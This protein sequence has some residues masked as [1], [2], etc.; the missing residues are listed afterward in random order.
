M[1]GSVPNIRAASDYDVVM[2]AVKYIEQLQE[3]LEAAKSRQNEV[4]NYSKQQLLAKNQQHLAASS[5]QCLA[6]S[7]IDLSGSQMG[8]YN[9][10][11]A[12]SSIDISSSG[13]IGSCNKNLAASSI[14]LSSSSRRQLSYSTTDLN[15]SCSSTVNLSCDASTINLSCD[16]FKESPLIKKEPPKAQP[17]HLF[18][19]IPKIKAASSQ[20]L[21]KL[22]FKSPQ[23]QRL[24]LARKLSHLARSP[25]KN[26]VKHLIKKDV[27]SRNKDTE[28]NNN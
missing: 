22:N 2:A 3:Q 12:A 26:F 11:L 8:Y 13:Q 23:K 7:S 15:E 4:E 16:S 5:Q 19:H 27:K 20:D 18:Q 25:K 9:N 24:Y 21:T 28:K 14:D 1:R 10:H 6:T 17:Q